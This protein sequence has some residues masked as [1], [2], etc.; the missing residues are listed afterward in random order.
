MVRALAHR[1]VVLKGGRIVEE[2]ETHRL[3]AA[4]RE[5]YTK[6]LIDA[7]FLNAPA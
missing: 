1:I 7:S 4:P 6:N 5:E 2:G 3:F